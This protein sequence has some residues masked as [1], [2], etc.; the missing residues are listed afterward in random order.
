MFAFLEKDTFPSWYTLV[1][2]GIPI[3]LAAFTGIGAGLMLTGSIGMPAFFGML[4]WAPAFYSTLE[5]ASAIAVLGLTSTV[6]ACTIGVL[7]SFILRGSILFPLT[8]AIASN[9]QHTKASMTKEHETLMQTLEEKL[10]KT[11][12]ALQQTDAKLASMTT[13]YDQLR[14]AFDERAAHEKSKLRTGIDNT[15]PAANQ[16]KPAAPK[17]G[18]STKRLGMA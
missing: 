6:L 13:Q 8:E 16:A 2:W 14:G 10:H 12:T 7:S 11:G 9:A 3:G 17:E 4:K 18:A 15:V 1:K 5:G